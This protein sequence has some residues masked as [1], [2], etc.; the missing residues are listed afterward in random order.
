MPTTIGTAW[1]VARSIVEDS[2]NA[3]MVDEAMRISSLG[4]ASRDGRWGRPVGQSKDQTKIRALCP[5]RAEKNTTR[6]QS[7]FR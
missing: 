2:E 6:A 5:I 1:R 4:K 7:I 3:I